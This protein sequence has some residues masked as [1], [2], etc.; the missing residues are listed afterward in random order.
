MHLPFPNAD[1]SQQ[2][3][4]LLNNND[5]LAF[6]SKTSNAVR[7]AITSL[8]QA[9]ILLP[10]TKGAHKSTSL[11]LAALTY[12]TWVLSCVGLKAFATPSTAAAVT[13]QGIDGRRRSTLTTTQQ[14]AAGTAV[15]AASDAAM[16]TIVDEMQEYLT[17]ATT[18]IED[19]SRPTYLKRV[20]Y[21]LVDDWK[22]LQT[23]VKRPR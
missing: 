9:V 3:L 23:K 17:V 20:F 16:P 8:K 5:T 14:Q 13:E 15:T 7:M 22:V 6:D 10:H 18:L 4:A 21:G 19:L 2:A 11:L 12:M 1:L